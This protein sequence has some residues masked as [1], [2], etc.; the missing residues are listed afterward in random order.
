MLSSSSQVQQGAGKVLLGSTNQRV[1]MHEVNFGPGH[2][3]Q[4]IKECEEF[5][6]RSEAK[7]YLCARSYKA[8]ECF[9]QCCERRTRCLNDIPDLAGTQG[10]TFLVSLEQGWVPMVGPASLPPLSVLHIQTWQVASAWNS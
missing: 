2:R 10:L 5:K 1:V 3:K 8:R 9:I 7:C 6:R 4:K